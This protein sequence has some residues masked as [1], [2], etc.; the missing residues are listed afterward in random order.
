MN[1]KKYICP[2][3]TFRSYLSS[4]LAS[5]VEYKVN[6]SGCT[7]E[8]FIPELSR[9]DCYCV[10]VSESDICLKQDTIYNYLEQK[11]VKTS[12]LQRIQTVLRSFGKYMLFV[13][14]IEDTYVLPH[15]IHRHGTTFIPYVFTVN[16]IKQLFK[17]A[18]HYELKIHNKPT[19][20]LVNCMRCIIKVLYCTGMR[21]SEVCNLKIEDV[22][23]EN[24]II[25]IKHAKNDNKR[26]VTIS[27][28]LLLEMKRY[29]N[30]S[31]T[32]CNSNKY[33]F[34]SGADFKEGFIS[35]ECVYSYFRKYLKLANIEHKGTGNGPRLHDLRVTFAVHSLKR[36][37]ESTTD[38]NA[39]LM[40]L[41][42]YMGHKSIYETQEYLWLTKDLYS[43][44]LRKMESYTSFITDIY[45]EKVGEYNE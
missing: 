16:E 5:F 38:V 30:E 11:S 35:P 26:I 31:K 39:A 45:N 44:T 15:L 42:A 28:T 1:R 27:S 37:T 13:L 24:C 34:D 32:H 18:D 40:Y 17:A 2:R 9:F 36:L 10:K 4:V 29:Q 23:L 25:Y 20:N 12:T 41:S 6:V 7:P 3:K 21:R 33:F 19:V 43:E 14:R 22:D 8:S